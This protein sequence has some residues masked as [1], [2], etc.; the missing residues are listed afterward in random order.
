MN[1]PKLTDK[2]LALLQSLADYAKVSAGDFTKEELALL[3]NLVALGLV[4]KTQEPSDNPGP[5]FC[6]YAEDEAEDRRQRRRQ[7]GRAI[8]AP[9]SAFL[10]G[11]ILTA[12]FKAHG[13][14][15]LIIALLACLLSFF[16][17]VL[18]QK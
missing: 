9:V 12:L 17:A 10:I 11:S 15:E 8:L 16:L 2:E 5:V 18:F 14:G 4:E 6:D 1:S 7:Y 3:D 13:L